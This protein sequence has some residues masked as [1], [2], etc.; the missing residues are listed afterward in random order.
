MVWD[1]L[2]DYHRARVR[3][4]AA[5]AGAANVF[6]ADLGAADGLYLWSNSEGEAGHSQL[7]SKPV[8]QPDFLGRLQAFRKLLN[9]HNINV[10]GIAGYG[11]PEYL[12]FMLLA[13]LTGR[14]TVLFAESWYGGP[15]LLNK[16]KG[17]LLKRLCKGFL[18]SGK[19]AESHFINNLGIK[20]RQIR[21]GYSVVD[22]EHFAAPGPAK[23]R[24]TLLCIA[25]FAPEKNLLNLIT[26]FRQSSIADS[27]SLQLVGGGPLSE[28]LH[29]A[30]AGCPNIILSKWLSYA[31]LPKVYNAASWFILPSIFEPWGLVVN[32]A[33]AAGLP[34]ILSESCGCMPDL[35]GP[36]NGPYNGFSF[37]D[38]EGVP[39][40]TEALNRIAQI[41][42]A[43][44]QAMGQASAE[45]IKQYSPQVW[46]GNFKELGGDC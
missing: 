8:E 23:G 30:A 5:Q 20:A 12:A 33:M 17:F 31:E 6:S 1:R 18:V 2:G 40:L 42:E 24:N 36:Y 46:A 7:S 4:L 43:E 14:K 15:S 45:R 37:N 10:V 32:E 38:A 29:Q 21:I 41:S 9:T 22:N 19:R 39:A 3:A 34:V 25:R 28:S 13:R 44:R 27:H 11:R 35:A 26:A 16:V